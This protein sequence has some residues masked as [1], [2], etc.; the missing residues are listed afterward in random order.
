MICENA[1]GILLT[2]I[3]KNAEVEFG[4]QNMLKDLGIEGI[5]V[6]HALKGYE[7]QEQWVNKLFADNDMDFRFVTDGDPSKF[8]D[9]L[10]SKY[11]NPSIHNIQ[12]EGIVSCT[13]NHILSYE[14]IVRNEHK[15][16]LVFEND[17]YFLNNFQQN[18]SNI[19]REAETLKPGF[20]ISLENTTLK[21]P[22]PYKRKRGKYLYEADTGRC[23][24]AYLI[25]LQAARVVLDDL[26]TKKCNDIIDWWHNDLIRRDIIKMYWAHP[27]LVE[28]CSHNGKMSSTISSK[29][30][31]WKR[32]VRWNLQ[33]FYK[34]YVLQWFRF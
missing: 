17:P 28:Q 20:I 9:N 33:K 32:Q 6:V 1:L 26:K 19:V 29:N 3:N 24:G 12:S 31:G 27:P 13:L 4:N 16:S 7:V 22:S 25:D 34:T 8:T 30:F 15:Y 14:E 11:F 10:L 23:A 21:F 18:I 5:Y 2:D